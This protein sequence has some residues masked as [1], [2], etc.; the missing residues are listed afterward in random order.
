M[1]NDLDIARKHFELGSKKFEEKLYSQAEKEFNSSLN[2][3]PNRVSTLSKLILCKIQLKKFQECEELLSKIHKIDK[4]AAC[5]LCLRTE[6]SF[7]A[8]ALLV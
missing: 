5:L 1:S 3:L 2:F 6:T 4:E 8:I 7:I